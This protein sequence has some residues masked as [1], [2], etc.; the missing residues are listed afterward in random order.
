MQVE[1]NTAPGGGG[2]KRSS[3]G[4]PRSV[5]GFA[6]NLSGLGGLPD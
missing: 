6:G 1:L 4:W 5:S 3:I 2:E